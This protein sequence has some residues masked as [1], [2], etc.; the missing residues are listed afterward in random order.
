MELFTAVSDD[1][2]PA[3]IRGEF[4][5]AEYLK[6]MNDVVERNLK[7]MSPLVIS[8][9]LNMR[10]RDVTRLLDQW[11]GI[12]KNSK[13]IQERAGMAVYAADQHYSMIINAL[14]DTVN[15]ADNNSDYRAKNGI[16]KSV[17]DVEQKRIDMLQKAGLLENQ[18][19]AK[20]LVEQEKKQE[21]IMNIL[22]EVA[23][24]CE[25][26]R[27]KILKRLS[28]VSEKAEGVKL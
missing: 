1:L 25:H 28:D 5:T 23:G 9:E 18:D 7:G 13:E 6:L 26:C 15:E 3:D 11:E 14:W 20:Q 8:R 24:E 27:A 19:L 16:L 10:M 17:A 2:V 21:A 22:R 12:A 4:D